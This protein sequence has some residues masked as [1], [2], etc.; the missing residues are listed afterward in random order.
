MGLDACATPMRRTVV[1]PTGAAQY[2]GRAADLSALFELH[3]VVRAQLQL[4]LLAGMPLHR[5]MRSA[6][7]EAPQLA[8]TAVTP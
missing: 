6:E 7:F 8:C 2:Q 4:A 3:P 5:L 1:G